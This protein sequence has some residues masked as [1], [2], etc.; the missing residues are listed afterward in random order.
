[1]DQLP[2]E[3]LELIS[4]FRYC[5]SVNTF[6]DEA[7]LSLLTIQDHML[8]EASVSGRWLRLCLPQMFYRVSMPLWNQKCIDIVYGLLVDAPARLKPFAFLIRHLLMTEASG[9]GLCRSTEMCIK[10]CEILSALPSL[11]TLRRL[12]Y[13]LSHVGFGVPPVFATPCLQSV[14]LQAVDILTALR[15]LF[16]PTLKSFKAILRPGGPSSRWLCLNRSAVTRIDVFLLPYIDSYELICLFV[17]AWALDWLTFAGWNVDDLFPRVLRFVPHVSMNL[18]VLGIEIVNQDPSLMIKTLMNDF[19][20]LTATTGNALFPKLKT[21]SV[22]SSTTEESFVSMPVR[23]TMQ[24]IFSLAPNLRQFFLGQDLDASD[25]IV[26]LPA[27]LKRCG[28]DIFTFDFISVD[29][30]NQDQ[31]SRTVTCNNYRVLGSTLAKGFPLKRFD[32]SLWTTKIV[33]GTNEREPQRGNIW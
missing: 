24:D 10:A 25:F 19:G 22:S 12:D 30:E 11:Q 16:L 7:F 28:S 2:E 31:A 33:S 29:R 8:A 6:T 3:V 15:W 5:P 17:C 27:A 18:V 21:F 14:D 9:A 23:F 1:M 32:G 20:S 26:S 13:S 4:I